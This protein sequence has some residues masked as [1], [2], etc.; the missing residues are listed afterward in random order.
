[1][2]RTDGA[3]WDLEI[4]E[5]RAARLIQQIWCERRGYV[6]IS[7][8]TDQGSQDVTRVN[9]TKFPLWFDVILAQQIHESVLIEWHI[10]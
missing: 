6:V 3:P 2:G 10:K 8:D 5:I 7:G 9:R 1:M 4:D